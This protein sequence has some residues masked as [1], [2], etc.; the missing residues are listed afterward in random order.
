MAICKDIPEIRLLMESEPGFWQESWRED[1]LERGIDSANCLAFVWEEENEI[2]GFICAHDLAFRGY[3]SEL[4][5]A[6]KARGKEIGKKLVE[7][8]QGK[9]AEVGCSVVIADVWRDAECFYKKLGWESPDV[10]LLRKKL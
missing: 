1:V 3:I 10:V 9:L 5:V 7:C 2:L 6:E 8:V 4:I